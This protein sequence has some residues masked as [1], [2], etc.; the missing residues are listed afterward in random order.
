L[1][2]LPQVD[3]VIFGGLGVDK[4]IIEV[5]EHKFPNELP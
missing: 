4:D 2:H 5:D 3:E 1:E